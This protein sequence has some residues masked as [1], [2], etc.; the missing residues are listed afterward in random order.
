MDS[1]ATRRTVSLVTEPLHVGQ[2]GIVDHEPVDQGPNAG[3]FHGKGP[4][5]ERAELFVVAEGTTPAGEAF[6]PH[7]VSAIGQLWTGL[8]MSV[9]GALQRCFDEAQRNVLD[10]NRKSI[11]QH[12]AAIGLTFLARKGDQAVIAQAGPTIAFHLSGQ[13]LAVY[14]PGE[15]HGEPFGANLEPKPEFTRIDL[16]PGDRVLI[17]STVALLDLDAALVRGILGLTGT[18]VLQDLYRRIQHL[19]NLTVLLIEVPGSPAAVR[20]QPPQDPEMIGGPV[21]GARELR[22]PNNDGDE[23]A[24]SGF[25]PSLF[26]ETANANLRSEVEAAREKLTHISERARLRAAAPATVVAVAAEMPPLRR[27]VGDTGALR[28]LAVDQQARA[29]MSHAS[30]MAAPGNSGWRASNGPEERTRPANSASTP[31]AASFSRSLVRQRAAQPPDRT[32]SDAQLASEMAASRRSHHAGLAH[33][34]FD[35]A[36][37]AS[38]AATTLVRPRATMGGRWR[39]SGSLARRSSVRSQAP[40]TRLVVVLGL[41]LLIALVG[42]F[43]IPGMLSGNNE[44][45]VDELVSGAEQHLASARV[46]DNPAEQRTALSQAMAMLLEAEQL[47]G[48]STTTESLINEVA[49]AISSLDAVTQPQRVEVI[50]DFAAFGDMP[51]TAT[52]VSI[53]PGFGYILD[54]TSGHVIAQPLDGTQA[55]VIY[56]EDADAVQARPGALTFYRT[57]GGSDG[58]GLLLIADTAGALWSYEPGALTQMPIAIPAGTQLTDITVYNGDLYILDAAAGRIIRFTGAGGTFP[59]DSTVAV[60]SSALRT[61][62]RFMVDDEIITSDADGTL[63]RYTG[64]LTLV[65]S[66]AGIDKPLTAA[67]APWAFDDGH[68]ALADPA[69]DRI[70]VLNRDGTFVRQYRNTEFATLTALAMRDDAGFVFA[71]GKLLRI[72]W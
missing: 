24:H 72:T 26:I 31:A 70:V 20:P 12:R 49:G 15:G 66:Q 25:Q 27:A 38:L 65:L 16:H 41:A 62:V 69:N 6:A 50:G 67:A 10:W 42:L 58:S 8:D 2:F 33:T 1:K 57:S 64:D 59:Y 48:T 34:S 23:H 11:A 54:S 32:G 39:G 56:E 53:G 36:S 14:E 68:I 51:V 13:R 9:T 71:G 3:I 47:G 55:T 46:Q 30:A 43:T 60:E 28:Q 44:G 40:S 29:S 22:A 63:R 18:Q 7:V 35:D 21:I 17:L 61:A 19:R 4:A 45:R 37:N 5:G 52:D